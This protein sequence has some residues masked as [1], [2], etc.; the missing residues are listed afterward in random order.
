M[1]ILNT[2][3]SLTVQTWPWRLQR[4]MH[5]YNE[6]KL[7]HSIGKQSYAGRKK[8]M[9]KEPMTTPLPVN[10]RVPNPNQTEQKAE[11]TQKGI[12]RQLDEDNLYKYSFPYRHNHRI[13]NILISLFL[14]VSSYLHYKEFF[15]VLR[16]TCWRY[17]PENAEIL[18]TDRGRP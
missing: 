10:L 7:A 18:T 8:I 6:Y 1:R 16:H 17:I 14:H 3:A 4:K 15:Q 13:T 9:S 12:G 11:N 5:V 2:N